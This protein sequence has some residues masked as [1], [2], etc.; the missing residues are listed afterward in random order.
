VKLE[1][2]TEKAQAALQAAAREAQER[3]QQAIEPDQLLLELVR[4]EGGIASPLTDEQLVKA[5]ALAM[6][7]D[8]EL[9][10]S[11]V[12]PESCPPWRYVG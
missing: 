4:Q 8:R 6:L 7:P 5:T 2:L 12:V 1:R 3:G 10:P 11:R 9:Q